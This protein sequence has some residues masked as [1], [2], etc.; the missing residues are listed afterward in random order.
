[1]WWLKGDD[2][3]CVVGMSIVKK[4]VGEDDKIKDCMLKSGGEKC[5]G[6][7]SMLIEGLIRMEVDT[8]DV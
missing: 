7:L 8:R 2:K 3:I 6:I 4:R 5:K 1:V